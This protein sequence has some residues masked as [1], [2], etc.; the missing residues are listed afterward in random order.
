M[1]LVF[2]PIACPT[3]T[4]TYSVTVTNDFG[5][6]STDEV[7]VTVIPGPT[8]DVAMTNVTECGQFDGTITVNASGL[9]SNYEYSI[10][11]GLT[12]S[13]NPTF[14]NLPASSYLVV[15]KGGG[16]EVPY[17]NNPVI[18]GDGIAPMITS[19]PLVHPDCDANNGSITINA[20]GSDLQYS[21]NGGINF[22]STNEFTNLG[23]GIYYIA[24]AANNS[25]CIT[26]FP[27]VELIQP[28]AP[29]IIDVNFYQSK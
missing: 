22:F 11:G 16:C 24:V 14:T 23:G 25:N 7:T 28:V 8:I 4:T 12:F 13:S 15:I 5:C 29:S 21:I 18:I 17:A 9:A 6:E 1:I 26:Y 19:V 10:D 20:N 3:E 27:P 2:N